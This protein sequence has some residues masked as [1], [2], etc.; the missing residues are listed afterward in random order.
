MDN[1]DPVVLTLERMQC[2]LQYHRQQRQS[3]PL[4][5]IPGMKIQLATP[6]STTP[7]AGTISL[8]CS[9]VH[10]TTWLFPAYEADTPRDALGDFLVLSADAAVW[11]AVAIEALDLFLESIRSDRASTSDQSQRVD[12]YTDGLGDFLLLSV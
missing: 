2:S 5:M 8:P 7:W 12:P 1:R 6:R 11:T 10:L 4:T 9:A 3:I